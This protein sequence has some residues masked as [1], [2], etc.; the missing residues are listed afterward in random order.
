MHKPTDTKPPETPAVL[1]LTQRSPSPVTAAAGVIAA[2]MN[3]GAA[4]AEEIAEAEE[5]AG[6]LFSPERADD[7]AD[8]ARAQAEAEARAEVE[9]LRE[10]AAAQEQ[11]HTQLREHAD[12]LQARLAAVLRLCSGR[13]TSHLMTAR[14]VLTAAQAP[15]DLAVGA[16][17]GM[18]WSGLV[19]G[20]SG[21]T[22][23]ELV[24]LP[25]TTALGGPA[26]LTLAMSDA[27]R[28]SQLLVRARAE[29]DIEARCVRCGCTEDAPCEGGCSWVAAAGMVDLCS[30]C[31]DCGTP[32]CGLPAGADEMDESDPMLW[33]WIH[34]R[35][36]GTEEPSRWVCSAACAAREIDARGE[37]LAA[38]DRAE[39]T[40]TVADDTALGG[41]DRG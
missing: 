26:A 39:G 16:P 34:V 21:N 17:L 28:L 29:D 8:A 2:T 19:T 4:T 35:V 5:R 12:K 33:G 9:R 15:G 37:E 40:H 6:L 20:P 1:P 3:D 18:H 38:A 10:Y 24:V 36:A 41:A 25:C 31:V 7:V 14:E 30:A 23:S 13:P 27:H 11:T 22:G 32:G